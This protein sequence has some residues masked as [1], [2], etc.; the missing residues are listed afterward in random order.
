MAKEKTQFREGKVDL[1]RLIAGF[2]NR[3]DVDYIRACLAS[4]FPEL[5]K[6]EYCPNCGASMLEY[7]FFFDILDA[8]LL[9]AMAKAVK[10]RKAGGLEFTIANQI[11]VPSLGTTL[12]I[13]C[14]TTQCSKLGL[15]AKVKNANG[16]QARGMW[17]ITE[18]GWKA[19]G[20]YAVPAQVKVF[21]N[22]IEERSDEL[23]TLEQAFQVHR[24]AVEA[25][26]MRAKAIKTDYR[27]EIRDYSPSDWVGFGGIHEGNLY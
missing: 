6:K 12:A 5:F 22:R 17:L 4:R 23:I 15:V 16:K 2:S 3:T 1:A 20:G 14:R 10:I 21:R 13:R 11:H 9:Y 25:S 26:I 24:D 27:A 8:L 19:L 18:R 7:I